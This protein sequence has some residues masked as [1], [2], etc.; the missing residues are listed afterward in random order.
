MKEVILHLDPESKPEYIG[1]GVDHI[2]VK[3]VIRNGPNA[4][5]Y[6]PATLSMNELQSLDLVIDLF[7][8]IPALFLEGQKDKLAVL[9]KLLQVAGS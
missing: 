5:L 6:R 9:A 3:L 4:M 7:G 8:T 1:P 2:A